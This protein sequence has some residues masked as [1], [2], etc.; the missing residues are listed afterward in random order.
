MDISDEA[1]ST[2]EEEEGRKAERWVVIELEEAYIH[3]SKHIPKLQK[4][5]KE[6]TSGGDYFKVKQ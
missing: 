3:C 1:I 6:K 2:M 4:V 5:E